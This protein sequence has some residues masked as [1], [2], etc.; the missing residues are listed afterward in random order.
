MHIILTLDVKLIEDTEIFTVTE[1][2]RHCCVINVVWLTNPG[3]AQHRI[4]NGNCQSGKDAFICCNCKPEPYNVKRG[5]WFPPVCYICISMWQ[6]NT[7]S[8]R[9]SLRCPEVQGHTRF[10]QPILLHPVQLFDSPRNH[11]PI[12]Q[13]LTLSPLIFSAMTMAEE[14]ANPDT[15]KADCTDVG[16]SAH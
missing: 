16:L 9:S 13:I 10:V 5:H 4:N 7:G 14:I 3:G 12:H 6:Y 2:L 11:T 15:I 1:A 8:L